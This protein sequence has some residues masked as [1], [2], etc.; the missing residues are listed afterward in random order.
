M[1]IEELVVLRIIV[2][3]D[4]TKSCERKLSDIISSVISVTSGNSD[5][6]NQQ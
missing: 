3:E 1:V 2:M 4:E 6:G 5:Y